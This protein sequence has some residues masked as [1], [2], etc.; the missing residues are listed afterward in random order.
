MSVTL[1]QDRF[2]D[3]GR[4]YRSWKTDRPGEWKSRPGFTELIDNLAHARDYAAG[5][6]HVIMAQARDKDTSPRSIARCFPHPTLKMRVVELDQN[7]GTFVLERLEPASPAERSTSGEP[8]NV[9]IAEKES[10]IS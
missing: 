6:V 2:E 3:K 10:T 5:V 1:W 8:Q 7:E 9:G 4:I